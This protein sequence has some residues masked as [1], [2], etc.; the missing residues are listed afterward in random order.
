VE[1]V[2]KTVLFCHFS[3][4]FIK[5][6]PY[7]TVFWS[8]SILFYSF[9]SCFTKSSLYLIYFSVFF[10]KN[11]GSK[12]AFFCF[13]SFW[14]VSSMYLICFH[15]CLICVLSIFIYFYLCLICV[16]SIFICVLSVSYLFLSKKSIESDTFTKKWKYK[17]ELK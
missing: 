7:C 15:L 10:I 13:L 2:S 6:P 1:K 9:L 3:A 5:N 17:I 4:F 11:R 8:F 12:T 14:I 16:L